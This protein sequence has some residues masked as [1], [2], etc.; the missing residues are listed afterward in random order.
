MMVKIGSHPVI[1]SIPFIFTNLPHYDFLFRQ[2]YRSLTYKRGLRFNPELNTINLQAMA[3]VEGLAKKHKYLDL[4]IRPYGIDYDAQKGTI[5]IDQSQSQND[6]LQLAQFDPALVQ[7][8]I[9]LRGA[10][11]VSFNDEQTFP[12][13]TV[14]KLVYQLSFNDVQGIDKKT[15]LNLVAQHA[16]LL[17]IRSFLQN[18]AGIF[19]TRFNFDVTIFDFG[20]NNLIEG[21]K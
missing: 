4:L 2:Q 6:Q 13:A 5:A 11:D 12:I 10:Q 8:Q 9:H 21:S 3:T 20:I 17:K 15:F 7:Q 18:F 14:L 1:V 16:G 19:G